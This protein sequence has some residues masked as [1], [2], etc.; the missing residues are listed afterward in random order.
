[1]DT[2]YFKVFQFPFKYG[3]AATALQDKFSIVLSE[4]IADKF[5]GNVNPVGK[6]ITADDSMQLTVTGVLQ[7]VPSNS[8]IRPTVLLPTAILESNPDFIKGADWYNTFADNYLRL[9]KNA[10]PKKLDAK[11]A[12]IVQLN[13][14]QDQK[15]NKVFA[16]PFSK[17]GRGK[18]GTNGSDN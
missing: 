7:H 18:F 14:A 11:I 10:D 8:T 4:E 5:F 15:D 9:K 16:V 12:G 1:M 13:Y 17:I 2:G 6:I 3:N